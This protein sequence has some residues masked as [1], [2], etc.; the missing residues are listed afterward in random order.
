M[1]LHAA[2]EI[3]ADAKIHDFKGLLEEDIAMGIVAAFAMLIMLVTALSIRHI[4]YEAF[5]VIHI[6]LFMLMLIS[7]GMHRPLLQTKSIYIII[8]AAC[9]WVSDRILRSSRMI[10]YFFGNRAVVHQLPHGGVRLVLR[11]SP[12]RAA[13]GGHV[14]LWIPSVRFAETHPFTIVSTNPLELVIS[15]QDGFT[16]ELMSLASKSSG[17]VLRASC[18]GPYGTIPNFG[19]FEHTILIAGGSGATF[20]FGVAL[21]LIHQN[22]PRQTPMIHFIWVIRHQGT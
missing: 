9:L 16:R 1:I 18:D 10:W 4:R 14:F 3:E 11:R 19:H 17:A 2:M 8:F 20:T 6:T 15:A 21:N 5:Y 12:W 7:I 22:N 13:P